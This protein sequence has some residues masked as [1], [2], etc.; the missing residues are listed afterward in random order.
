ML[1]ELLIA[2][3]KIFSMINL[4]LNPQISFKPTNNSAGRSIKS[5]SLKQL[6][7]DTVCFNGKFKDKMMKLGY[8]AA[9]VATL[10]GPMTTMTSCNSDNTEITQ[11]AYYESD[12]NVPLDD[13]INLDNIELAEGLKD[14]M[15]LRDT[16]DAFRNPSYD[17]GPIKIINCDKKFLGGFEDTY[18][19]GMM[20]RHSKKTPRPVVKKIIMNND[21]YTLISGSNLKIDL[22]AEGKNY[23]VI[24]ENIKFSENEFSQQNIKNIFIVGNSIRYNPEKS[25]ID[26]LCI[27]GDDNRFSNIHKQVDAFGTNN[28]LK[29]TNGFNTFN[30]T[31]LG[32]SIDGK[33]SDDYVHV[34]GDKNYIENTLDVL[35]E[36][37]KNTFV[38]PLHESTAQS[39][40]INYTYDS[41]G[42][43]TGSYITYTDEETN[44]SF[45][46][47]QGLDDKY[48]VKDDDLV[49]IKELEGTRVIAKGEHNT[50]NLETSVSRDFTKT[51]VPGH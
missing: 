47:I 20:V 38:D 32:N 10:S 21:T 7:Q 29:G 27:Y 50:W 14:N 35:I 9:M 2:F 34:I 43:I 30:V 13:A 23:L 8:S 3:K 17:S 49:E 31:G 46:E 15:A 25:T 16:L 19:N 24:G 11:Q 45:D 37:D 36:G 51:E 6:E 40:T 39:S 5:C 33:G 12:R 41:K 44:L 42:N 28:K 4:S 22:P 18:E 26:N 48:G 1:I